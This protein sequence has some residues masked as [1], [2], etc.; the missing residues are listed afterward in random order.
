MFVRPL[1]LG[2]MSFRVLCVGGDSVSWVKV[3]I[4]GLRV[5]LLVRWLLSRLKQVC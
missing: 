2:L 1:G 5:M 4:I 3:L